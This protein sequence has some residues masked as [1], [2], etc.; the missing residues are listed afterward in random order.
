MIRYGED[1]GADRASER[2]HAP[3]TER[4][5]DAIAAILAEVLP[6][7]GTVVEIASG[8]GEHVV[9]FAGLFP[10]L[11][12]QPSD[13]DAEALASIRAWAAERSLPNLS[14][15]IHLDAGAEEWPVSEA[16]AIIAIN[17]VHISPWSATVGLLRGAARLLAAGAPL[18]L[19]GPYRRRDIPTAP[20]N[21]SFDRSL[22]SRDPRWGLREVETVEAEASRFQLRLD[23][24]VAMPANNLILVFSRL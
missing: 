13:G 17:M 5:R 22:R 1:L 11:R 24:L 23:R 19:Y 8:T 6:A 21:E 2:R 16:D 3:A 12:W 7:H 18:I 20:S 4:N 9:Y 10:E 15:P 14:D